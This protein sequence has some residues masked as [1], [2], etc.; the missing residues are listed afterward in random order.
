MTVTDVYDTDGISR[1]AGVQQAQLLP[2]RVKDA[3][4]IRQ[5]VGTGLPEGSRESDLRNGNS[6]RALGLGTEGVT[7]CRDFAEKGTGRNRILCTEGNSA[8]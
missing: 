1:K 4:T 8:A 7:I 6:V 5:F 3:E 2:E